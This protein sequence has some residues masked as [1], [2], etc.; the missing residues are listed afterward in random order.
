MNQGTYDVSLTV[1]NAFGSD[2]ETKVGVVTFTANTCFFDTTIGTPCTTATGL[3]DLAIVDQPISIHPNPSTGV[4]MVD[5]RWNMD[6]GI[7]VFD[8]YGREV[9]SHIIRH[10]SYIEVDMSYQP[11]G[12]YMVRVGQAV[13][14]LVVQ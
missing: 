10:T 6:D 9:T 2:N 1:D 14:K 5:G 12:A 8:L 11:K 7:Q 4:F 13:S 3:E